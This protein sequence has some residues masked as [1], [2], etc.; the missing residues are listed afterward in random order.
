MELEGGAQ[1][2]REKEYGEEGQHLLIE[3]NEDWL[4][5]SVL[6]AARTSRA[7]SGMGTSHRSR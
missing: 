2:Q 6:R 3:S 1:D 4:R 7:N 5:W